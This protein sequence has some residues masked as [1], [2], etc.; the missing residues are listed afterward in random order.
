VDVRFQNFQK[1]TPIAPGEKG[2]MVVKVSMALAKSDYQ[3][4]YRYLPTLSKGTE[5]SLTIKAVEL[6]KEHG[7]VGPV[8][9]KK[10]KKN[11]IRL[12]YVKQ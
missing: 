8:K 3:K 1:N 4:Y 11:I 12:N 7:P 5:H 9:K 6:L 10:K 2:E